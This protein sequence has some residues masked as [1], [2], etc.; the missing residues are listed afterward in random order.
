[1]SQIVKVFTGIL[2]LMLLTMLG[3][4][5]IGTQLESSN[6]RAYRQSV[7]AEIENSNFCKE[8]MMACISQAARDG[9]ELTLYVYQ[10]GEECIQMN[11][12]NE[13]QIEVADIEMVEVL[14]NYDYSIPFL[15]YKTRHCIRGYAI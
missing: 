7:A 15:N 5:I 12:E 9:Y 6:A 4:G 13:A 3:S 1:M 11:E 10:T 14:L 8:V 2:F